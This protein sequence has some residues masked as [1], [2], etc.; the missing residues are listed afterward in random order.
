MNPQEIYK[1]KLCSPDRIVAQFQNDWVI[2]SD[3]A[4]AAPLAI[5]TALGNRAEKGEL[6]SI[7]L[8]SFLDVIPMPC[9]DENLSDIIKG[10]TW[11]SAG[12]GR[13][14]VAKGI[15]DVMPCHYSDAPAL[16]RDYTHIDTFCVRV[17]P[18]DKHG[19]FTTGCSA[20]ISEA[21]RNKAKRIYVEV[22]EN[23]P[24][25]LSGPIIHISQ[26]EA[27]CEDNTPLVQLPVV[28]SDNESLAIGSLIAE[29]IANGSTLQLGIGAI[30]NEVAK[31][32]INKKN[33][34]IHTEML[35]DGMIDLIQAGAVDN[36]LK[37]IHTGRTVATFA[38]GSK[39]IYDYIDDNP[40]CLMLPVDYVNNPNVIATHPNFV[41][42]NAAVE[43][44]FF[45]QVSAESIGT[46]HISGSGG[47]ADYVRG[48]VQSKGGKSFIAFPS[49]S[50]KGS[51]SKIVST[52]QP[53]SI[54]TTHKNEVDHVVTEYGIA[55]LRGHTLGQ[56]TKAL[57]SIAHPK[58]REELTFEA[59]KRNI[60]I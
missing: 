40:A 20:S 38:L 33:L 39:K 55:K 52:L 57:I 30:P 23:M 36:S 16:I 42:V 48:A 11:F 43:V 14:A 31:A 4:L 9:Y 34:G 32:L 50:Q 46:R 22:N 25:A 49:T 17:S 7:I 29:E 47:Q 27:L 35:T 15:A 37:P 41:S 28:E 19:Y 53:G 2:V 1:Q 45:G 26:V 6:K 54:V 18:M 13:G 51:V 60:I 44:D 58:F 10:T 3:A 24:R 21:M 56:R 12:G 8:N 5:Y 59:K